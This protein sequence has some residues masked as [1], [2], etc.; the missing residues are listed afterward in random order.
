MQRKVFFED[1]VDPRFEPDDSINPWDPLQSFSGGRLIH[2]VSFLARCDV[3]GWC[4][5]KTWQTGDVTLR[6]WE[7]R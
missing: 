2:L 7:L 4:H 3:V 1:G 6:V 5:G